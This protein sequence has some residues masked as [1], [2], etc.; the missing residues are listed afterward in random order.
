MGDIS[1]SVGDIAPG[2]NIMGAG[3]VVGWAST[4][5]GFGVADAPSAPSA[6][7]VIVEFIDVG[8]IA[9]KY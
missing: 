1:A 4:T 6:T 3:V 2:N 7:T 5:A 8:W 9:Q